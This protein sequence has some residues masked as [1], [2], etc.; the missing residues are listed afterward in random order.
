MIVC[1][2]SLSKRLFHSGFFSN[3]NLQGLDTIYMDSLQINDIFLSFSSGL[4]SSTE[5]NFNL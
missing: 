1:L 3:K 4:S 5:L 2:E